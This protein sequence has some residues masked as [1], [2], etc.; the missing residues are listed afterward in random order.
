MAGSVAATRSDPIFYG[1]YIVGAS[2][3]V[4]F[5]SAGIGFYGLPVFLDPL[6]E[7]KGFSKPT[8]SLAM[9]LYFATSGLVAV[10][11]GW[12]V[13]R[14]GPRPTL[15]VGAVVMTS[16]LLLL[17]HITEVWQLFAVY[18]MMSTAFSLMGAVSV[19]ALITRW[20]IKKRARALSLSMTGVS[21]AGVILV[22]LFTQVIRH[23]GFSEATTVLAAMVALGVIPITLLVLKDRPED[24][25]LL[26]DGARDRSELET[27]GLM[28]YAAQ[29]RVWTPSSAIQTRAFWAIALGFTFIF[30]GQTGYLM[31]QISFLKEEIGTSAAALAVSVTAA[32]SICGRLAV[33]TVADR[34]DKK[35]VTMVCFLLQG[36]AI[37]LVIA[38]G[39]IVAIYAGTMIVGLTI[40]NV[41]MM[42]SLL[43][44]EAFGMT[45]FGAVF[46]MTA[47]LSQTVSSIG[48]G[49]IGILEDATGGYELPFIITAVLSWVAAAIISQVRPPQAAE[50]P[51]VAH[52]V[53]TP[54]AEV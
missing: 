22:P 29:T 45:S 24:M 9:T 20:F 18:F 40:G 47:L 50:S 52:A 23:W 21:L 42:Q 30:I 3:V 1:W 49:L 15:I 37:L 33:G 17:G 27:G 54:A 41:Y 16:A 32:A 25:G 43:V 44:G 28:S 12:L 38:T 19:N 51:A 36:V 7:L 31:H 35:T 53:P 14:R 11:A 34:L 26:P 6:N 39:N 46:G 10:P 4:I 8:I 48:P 5:T 13:D 2:A